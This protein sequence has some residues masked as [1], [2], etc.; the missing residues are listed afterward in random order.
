[1]KGMNMGVLEWK[2]REGINTEYKSDWGI[3]TE[4][5]LWGHCMVVARSKVAEPM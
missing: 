5:C 1:M 3:Y 2:K 4:I